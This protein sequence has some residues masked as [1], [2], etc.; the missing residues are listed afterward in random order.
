MDIFRKS[1]LCVATWIFYFVTMEKCRFALPAKN[2]K[3]IIWAS[4]QKHIL[5]RSVDVYIRNEPDRLFVYT[6][7]LTQLHYFA[8]INSFPL[9]SAQH[10]LDSMPHLIPSGN[11]S[12]KR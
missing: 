4:V 6:L 2:C 5:L 9:N 10:S 3:T 7:I 1:F 11:G 8:I 12:G